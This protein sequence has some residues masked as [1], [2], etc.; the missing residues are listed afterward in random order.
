MGDRLVRFLKWTGIAL[1]FLIVVLAGV[2]TLTV[3]WRPLL[4][5]RMRPV[6]SRRF[7]ATPARLERGRYLATSVSGCVECHTQRSSTDPKVRTGKP[8][9]GDIFLEQGEMRIVA[10]NI[11]PDRE[12]GIGAWS[13]DEIARAIREGVDRNGRTLFPIMPYEH[14]RHMSDEDLASVVVYIRSLEPVKNSLPATRIPF[15]VSRLINSTPE[16]V[17][18]PVPSPEFK[19]AVQRGEYMVTMGGCTDCHTPIDDRHMPMHNLEFAGGMTLPGETY[20]AANITP[21]PSGIGYYDEA[22]FVEVMR[23]GKVKARELRK[24]MPWWVYRNMTDEDLK[25]MF[26]YLRTVKPVAHRVDNSEPPTLCR[27][28]RQ[29]HGLGDKN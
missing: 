21:D 11:T 15:P 28:C 20:A 16:P 3:G 27:I 24:P 18:A 17:T 1:L 26:A 8:G 4:G 13:D 6:T 9:A 19:T 5:P 29:K 2:I 14:F 7:D 23:T 12:T 10:E 22:L 25:S